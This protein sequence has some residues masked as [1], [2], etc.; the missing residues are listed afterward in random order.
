MGIRTAKLFQTGGSQAVRLPAEF[1]FEGKEVQIRK[2]EVTGEVILMPRSTDTAMDAGQTQQLAN[3]EAFFHETI[4][5]SDE[6]RKELDG[7]LVDR[8]LNVIEPL[9]DPFGGWKE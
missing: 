9:S 3:L 2:D 4:N 8:P 5:I 1:R 6:L 7:F